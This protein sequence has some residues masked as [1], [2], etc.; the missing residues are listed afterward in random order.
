MKKNSHLDEDILEIINEREKP[1]NTDYLQDTVQGYNEEEFI[2]HFR[3]SRNVAEN[4]G[5]HFKTSQYYHYQAGRNGKLEAYEQ[6][7]IYLWFVGHQTSSFRDV[8]DRFNIA[9]STLFKIIRK[10]T[11]FLS[12]MAP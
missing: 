11:Y 6:T 3:I 5:E 10:L 7:L 2:E 4:I 9:I 1:K 12:N 8:S